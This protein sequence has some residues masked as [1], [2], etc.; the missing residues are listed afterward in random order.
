MGLNTG[1]LESGPEPKADG[2][3]LSHLGVPKR[4][5]KKKKMKKTLPPKPLTGKT[6]WAEFC[7]F[8]QP[9]GFKSGV[10]G[11]CGMAGVEAWGTAVLLW[12]RRAGSPEV[13]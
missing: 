11:V 13:G 2:Q 12:R 1:N 7:E 4:I 3:L 6:R 10:V 9:A 8:L 5:F